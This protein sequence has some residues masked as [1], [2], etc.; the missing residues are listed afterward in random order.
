MT[1]PTP[2]VLDRNPHFIGWLPMPRLY[3]RFLAPIVSCLIVVTIVSAT[4]I[5]RGQRSPGNGRW[6]DDRTRTLVGIVYAEP[7]AMLRVPGDNPSDP[8]VTI[9]LVEEGK[10]GAKNR[11]Q[12]FHGRPVRVAG[13]MLTRDGWRMLE[14]TADEDSFH[15]ADV[16]ENEVA[17]LKR[18]AAR[19][20]GKV[21]LRGEIVDSK[22]YLGAMKPGGG[23]THR[24][25]ALLCLKGGIPPLFVSQSDGEENS[26]YLLVNENFEPIN[27]Q[28][29]D[30]TGLSV[31]VEGIVEKLDDISIIRVSQ[32]D[33]RVE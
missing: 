25:C 3:A 29:I 18:T 32:P 30:L 33:I 13:T 19:R 9:L 11:V 31:T 2:P 5:A 14:L 17:H 1:E 27:S 21:S 23:R 4:L 8:P 7:Y 26:T 24:G 10:F 16:S 12:P 20:I 28:L 22:C 6:E 15:L